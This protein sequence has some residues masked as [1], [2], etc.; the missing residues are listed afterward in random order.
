M[1]KFWGR[2]A[3]VAATI[4][5][6]GCGAESGDQP[7][8]PEVDLAQL[9]VG[10][11][12][13]EPRTVK[14]PNE[15]VAKFLEAQRL[16]NAMPLPLDFDPALEYGTRDAP[17]AFLH[18]DEGAHPSLL[19]KW[20]DSGKF[21]AVAKNMVSGFTTSAQSHPELALSYEVVNSAIIFAD[22]ASAAAAAPALVGSLDPQL[23]GPAEPV[24]INRYPGTLSS[25]YAKDQ[26]LTTAT[27]RGPLLYV[28][29]VAEWERKELGADGRAHAIELTEK[30]IGAT[31]AALVGFRP[32]PTDRLLQLPSD[33]EGLRGL[34]VPRPREGEIGSWANVPGTYDGRGA[35][36]FASRPKSMRTLYADNGVDRYTLDRGIL[37]RARDAAAARRVVEDMRAPDRRYVVRTAPKALP[38]ARCYERLGY[39]PRYICN[40]TVGRYIAQIDSAQLED[41]QQAIS[42]QYAILAVHEKK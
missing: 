16:G 30:A 5:I 12:P 26:V 11:Y 15:M 1:R 28:T 9:D 24:S 38:Q 42:A 21:A 31:S 4:L 6:A 17:R 3:V 7:T 8:E 27:V 41:A 33:P 34:S 19:F 36:H 35:L 18:P 39:E 13:R 22:H 40:L 32:T 37:L 25:W 14:P 2:A 10:N 20:T 23:Y 29:Q